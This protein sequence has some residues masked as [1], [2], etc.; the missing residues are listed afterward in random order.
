MTDAASRKPALF[1]RGIES[2]PSN[3]EYAF[4]K[5]LRELTES[6]PTLE[7]YFQEAMVAGSCWHQLR[8]EATTAGPKRHARADEP[9]RPSAIGRA[10]IAAQISAS[11][12]L[13]AA[14]AIV[15]DLMVELGYDPRKW[16]AGR[17]IGDG[18]RFTAV[19]SAGAASARHGYEWNR[20]WGKWYL[21]VLSVP[22]GDAG[23]IAALQPYENRQLRMISRLESSVK[24]LAERYG[25]IG[26]VAYET[27]YALS[28]G[29]SWPVFQQQLYGV[30][31]AIA[32]HT[33]ELGDAFARARDVLWPSAATT[34]R[35]NKQL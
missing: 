29:G 15:E 34:E 12:V 6:L 23:G 19:L 3:A 7:R 5:F 32:G 9:F 31:S 16:E 13:V 11:S 10:R 2:F 18:Y 33:E 30:A 24:S 35:Q 8:D 4:L 14:F 25:S 1:S 27:L 20:S 17:E 26:V 28:D 21:K 22:S